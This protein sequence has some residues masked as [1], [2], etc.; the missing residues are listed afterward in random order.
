MDNF[1]FA[2]PAQNMPALHVFVTNLLTQLAVRSM[3]ATGDLL[4]I[5]PARKQHSCRLLYAVVVQCVC[6]FGQRASGAHHDADS[7][8]PSMYP[9]TISQRKYTE[10]ICSCPFVSPHPPEIFCN[11]GMLAKRSN[12]GK[13]H[14]KSQMKF[15]R[16]AFQSKPGVP[17]AQGY[18]AFRKSAT[19]G[20]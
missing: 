4:A 16:P 7:A 12:I 6:L 8:P 13:Q 5:E 20:G 3:V 9:N 14:H 11:V 15:V 2:L 19:K 10:S 17:S 1:V 18:L